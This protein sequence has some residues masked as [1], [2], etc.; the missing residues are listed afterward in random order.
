M[1]NRVSRDGCVFAGGGAHLQQI[2][3]NG[4]GYG[5]TLELAPGSYKLRLVVRDDLTGQIGS[6]SAPL[7]LK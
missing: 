7:E 3:I 1:R 2:N 5:D 6:V 4:L